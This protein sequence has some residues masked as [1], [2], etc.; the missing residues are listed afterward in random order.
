[1]IDLDRFKHIND[2]LGHMEGD[3]ALRDMAAII[4]GCIRHSDFAAR[5]GGDEFVIAA[6]AEYDIKKLMARIQL[7]IDVQNEKHSRPY[8]IEM[9]YGYDVYVTGQ[10]RS[11]KDFMT[12]IDQLM[13][14]HKETRRR[15][16]GAPA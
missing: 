9:S 7:A 3:N 14:Q 2:T 15:M 10:N 1:M 16:A 11:I 13:Y 4:K 5:Y 6:P 8:Q 12:H